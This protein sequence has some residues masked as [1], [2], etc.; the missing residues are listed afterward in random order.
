LKS[1]DL[2]IPVCLFSISEPPRAFRPRV[3]HAVNDW[4]RWY[5]ELRHDALQLVDWIDSFVREIGGIFAHAW[6]S[7]DAKQEELLKILDRNG[8]TSFTRH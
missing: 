1:S 4:T 8:A 3:I 2:F 5:T 7:I 6:A